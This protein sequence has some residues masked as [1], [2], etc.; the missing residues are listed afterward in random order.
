M[1]I[2]RSQKVFEKILKYKIEQ[3]QDLYVQSN[4]LL[5][6][7]AFENFRNICLAIHE[8]DHAHFLKA[9]GKRDKQSL[10]RQQ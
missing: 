2:I 7:D 6:T 9:S 3:Y 8:L 5:L 4:T 1:Q 10:K